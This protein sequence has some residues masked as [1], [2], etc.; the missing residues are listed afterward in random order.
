MSQTKYRYYCL[1][2]SGQLHG[3]EWFY[4][5]NDQAAIKRIQKMHPD[6]RCEIWQASRLV[7]TLAP[8]RRTASA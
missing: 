3:T 1:D 8:E 5:D 7:A 6:D 2:S 4:A